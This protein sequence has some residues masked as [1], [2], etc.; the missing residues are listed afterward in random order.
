MAVYSAWLGKQ[1][2]TE[3]EVTGRLIAAPY[4]LESH[5]CLLTCDTGYWANWGTAADLISA[6]NPELDQRCSSDNCKT[7]DVT[8]HAKHC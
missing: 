1:T 5:T 7:F 3:T 2:Y 6:A 4:R 8:Q